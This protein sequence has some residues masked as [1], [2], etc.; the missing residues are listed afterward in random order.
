[1]ITKVHEKVRVI[2]VFFEDGR[3]PSPLRMRWAKNDYELGPVDFTH[4]TKDGHFF[5]W[6]FS[7][8][9][10]AESMFFKLTLQSETLVW[11]LEEYED[12]AR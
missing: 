9:D 3:P 10:K 6:H 4:T 12:T 2:A 11:T 7:L 8:C 1:M 5:V